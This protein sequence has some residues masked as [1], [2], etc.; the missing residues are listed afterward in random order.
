MA[1][2][3]AGV[4]SRLLSQAHSLR[5]TASEF[6]A[7]EAA[8]VEAVSSRIMRDWV[9][10]EDQLARNTY[11]GDKSIVSESQAGPVKRPRGR[12]A[13]STTSA[14]GS[15]EAEHLQTSNKELA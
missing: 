4:Q 14:V 11:A 7:Q 10:L 8:R 1:L 6:G 3:L 13:K 9:E 12:P 5:E 15:V 2:E